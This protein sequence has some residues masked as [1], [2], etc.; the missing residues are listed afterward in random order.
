MLTTFFLWADP[1]SIICSQKVWMESVLSFFTI[2]SIYLFAYA[3]QRHKDIYFLFAGISAGLA[4]L[5]KYPGF[6]ALIII[7]S[8]AL[9]YERRLL[10]IKCS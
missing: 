5:T 8:Y 10:K 7:L 2:L 1:V 4:A 3:V 6:L 9:G